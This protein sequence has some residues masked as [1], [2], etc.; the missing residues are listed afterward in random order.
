MSG[1]RGSLRPADRP[2]PPAPPVIN[3]TGIAGV[4]CAADAVNSAFAPFQNAPPPEQG[5]AGVVS[6]KL[7]GV[8]GLVGAPA[9]IIDNAFA[10]LTAP[11]AALFPSMPAITLLG[12]HIGA[13]H[14]HMHPPS[15]ITPAPPVP[16]PSI[17]ML[18]GSG[19][20]SV[21]GG[22]MPL[23][24]AG[25]I[26]IS[27]TC[28][29][30][31]P[32]F[33]VYT[34]SSNVFVGGARAARILD[35]TKHCNP[36]SAGPFDI[37]M[38]AAGAVA[39]AAGAIATNSLV[40]AAQ[41]A[42]D[43]AV[44]AFKLLCG[45][46]PGLPPGMGALLGPPVPTV[47]IGGFPCSA[48]RRH[49]H[50]RDDEE[51]QGGRQGGRQASVA[52][53]QRPRLRWLAPDLPGTGENFDSFTD[54]VSP[55]LFR[56]ERHY[57]TGRA[58]VD[59]PLGYG[60]RH[61]YQRTLDVR[62][63]KAT[64]TDWDGVALEFPKF[65]AGGDWV[66]SHGYVLRRLSRERYELSTYGQPTMAFAGDLFDQVL[67][68]VG[69]RDD[70]RELTFEYGP[71]GALTGVTDASRTGP[72]QT[73]YGFTHDERG[74]I[75]GIFEQ[76][77][78]PIGRFGCSYSPAGELAYVRDA[79]NGVWAYQYDAQHRWTRQVDPREYGYSFKYDAEGRCV[80]ACGDDGLWKAE[81]EYF[82]DERFTRYVEGEGAVWEYHYD[83]DGFVTKVLDPNGGVRIRVVDAEGRVV[84]DIDPGGRKLTFLY[85]QDGATTGRLDRFGYV[86]PP[87]WENPRL[88]NPFARDLPST[89]LARVFAGAIE[90]VPEAMLGASG[91]LLEI[92]GELRELAR[93]VFR[94][95]GLGGPAV[96]RETRTSTNALGQEV[97]EI[98]GLNRPRRHSYDATGNE[99]ARLDR[100]G[101]LY[102]RETTSWNLLG[103]R[104]DPLGHA[105]R[106]QYD[107]IEKIVGIT[108]PLGTRA[109]G[110]TIS[111]NG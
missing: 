6:Q 7:G 55:G 53:R 57:T 42:A 81:A 75:T 14:A 43:A 3:P 39:G 20:I 64:F 62:L 79:N 92:P 71:T 24:R 54:F 35:I 1:E 66:R 48:D 67:P 15:F 69:L 22:G 82:P 89:A 13:M 8:L 50:R 68:L 59:G 65:G 60:F 87:E 30:P 26:G 107:S 12:M 33:E 45:K 9:Q 103:A 72:G 110:S 58:S 90:A 19:A 106:F 21:L 28:G 40:A 91:R 5:A 97:Y 99:I 111:G 44:L 108:D 94:M 27:V 70:E 56:W 76:D 10:G 105:V 63:H 96:A 73:H 61:F 18:V 83:T 17:G 37:A 84:E 2:S 109:A 32:P 100:D 38:G 102:R 11:L 52:A 77:R 104:I 29:S 36:T 25:D 41:V 80:Y 34:G 85:D 95:R 49:D 78:T 16:L 31:A 101:R 23:A 88:G 51:A 47:M 98:D 86:H 74:R 93:G 46:D 4:D